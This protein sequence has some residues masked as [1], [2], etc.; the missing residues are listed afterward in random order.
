MIAR[1]LVVED[2]SAM[3]A[4]VRAALEEAGVVREVVEASS[5]FEALRLLP[6]ESFGLAIVDINMPDVNGLELIRFM[7]GSDAHKS[8]PLLVISSEASERDRERGL[9]LGANAYLAKPFTAEALVEAVR[10]LVPGAEE[11]QAG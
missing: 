9:S 3:R 4:Y 8:T 7:R 10:E 5:G 11:D 1:I 2:S 6:R